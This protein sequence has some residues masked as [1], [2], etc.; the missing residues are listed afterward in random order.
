VGPGALFG[1]SSSSTILI[2]GK[3]KGL[4]ICDLTWDSEADIVITNNGDNT[5]T[6]MLSK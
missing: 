1:V 3:P 2:G 5:I 4:A 6:V